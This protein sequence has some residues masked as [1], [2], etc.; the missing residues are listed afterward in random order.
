MD[1]PISAPLLYIKNISGIDYYY[2]FFIINIKDKSVKI[3]NFYINF[4]ETDINLSK[5]LISFT[6][7]KEHYDIVNN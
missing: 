2:L 1:Y 7:W 6:T 5:L 4:L 3:N